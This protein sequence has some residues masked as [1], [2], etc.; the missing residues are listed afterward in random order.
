MIVHFQYGR[1]SV[2]LKN[3][4]KAEFLSQ[5]ENYIK[6][7]SADV[8]TGINAY[9]PSNYDLIIERDV[10]EDEEGEAVTV[11]SQEAIEYGQR[12]HTCCVINDN[13]STPF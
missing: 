1:Y 6:T 4:S 7:S 11:I 3:N 12:P 9:P 8:F 10:F 13:N 2:E 5:L